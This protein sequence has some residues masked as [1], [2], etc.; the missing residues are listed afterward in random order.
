MTQ[1]VELLLDDLSE[2]TVLEQWRLLDAAGLPSQAQHRGPTNRP[3]VTLAVV[4]SVAAEAELA[5]ARC[6]SEA[7]PLEV[8]LGGLAAFGRDPVVLV[9]LVV[10]TRELLDLHARVA[11]AVALPDDTLL[12]PGRW[13]P[14][15]TL[16]RR[17]PLQQLPD[18]LHALD[19]AVEARSGTQVRL[20]AARRW[21]GVARRTWSL[22]PSGRSDLVP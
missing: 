22:H 8:R 14:H 18:A 9:R 19:R 15:V 7:L 12:S 20:E 17:M 5:L 13:T 21:D 10:V 1:S 6:C 11:G 3:H 16:A 2:A 4:P